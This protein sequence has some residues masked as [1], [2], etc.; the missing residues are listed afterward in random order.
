[1]SAG[2]CESS[3]LLASDCNPVLS[4]VPE[5]GVA[6]GCMLLWVAKFEMAVA[7]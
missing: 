5:S 1:M 6:V 4:E 2:A 3:L 7:L